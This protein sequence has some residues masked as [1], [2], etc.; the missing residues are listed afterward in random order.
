MSGKTLEH[1]TN[2]IL[3]SH[4]AGDLYNNIDTGAG[5]QMSANITYEILNV[6]NFQLS[7]SRE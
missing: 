7:I 4:R 6:T 3:L 1:H 5:K 2:E